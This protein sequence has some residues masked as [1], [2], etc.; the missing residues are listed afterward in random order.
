VQ[1]FWRRAGLARMDGGSAAGTA[2]AEE[3]EEAEE[4][5]VSPGAAE[6]PS[7]AMSAASMGFGRGVRASGR[8][9]D[10]W[11]ICKDMNINVVFG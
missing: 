6:G 7:A 2:A 5:V 3:A 11:R 4:V 1:E 8:G 10:L 9:A